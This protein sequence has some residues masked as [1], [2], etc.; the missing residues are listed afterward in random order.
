M[1]TFPE[2]KIHFNNWY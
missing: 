1:K 2:C